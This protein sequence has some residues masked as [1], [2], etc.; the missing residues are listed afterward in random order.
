M[1]K[2]ILNKWVIIGILLFLLGIIFKGFFTFL[3]FWV[4]PSFA[5]TT[6]WCINLLKT[7]HKE[8]TIGHLFKIDFKREDILGEF[9]PIFLIFLG[10][11]SG[12]LTF[13]FAHC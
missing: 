2:K 3:A 11:I 4:Y 10:S 8:V 1:M 7:K 13:R 6:S 5:F 12:W 9:S